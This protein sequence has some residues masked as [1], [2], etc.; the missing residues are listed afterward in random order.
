M[1]MTTR[2][3]RTTKTKVIKLIILLKKKL[4]LNLKVMMKR[5]SILL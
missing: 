5:Q 2:R 3:T 4:I 1:V